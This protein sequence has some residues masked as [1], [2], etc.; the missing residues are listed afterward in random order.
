MKKISEDRKIEFINL[1]NKGLNDKDIAEIMG[2]SDSSI[3]RWRHEMNLEA[4][5]YHKL[6]QNKGIELTDDNIQILCGTLLG[7]GSLQYYEKH[8]FKAPIFKCDHGPKQKEYA[9]QLVKDFSNLKPTLHKYERIDKRNNHLYITYCVKLPVNPC[10][11]Q[12]YNLLYINGKKTI[13]KE[14]LQYFT[15]KSLAYLYMDDGYADQK[16][17]YICTDNFNIDEQNIL[18]DYLL[19]KFN[20]HFSS[21]NHGKYRRLRLSQYDFD[22]FCSLIN[23]YIIPSLKYKLNSVT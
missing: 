3:F 17:A 23:P 14:F 7:D 6:A 8:R 18:I 21:V 9:E 16:T 11:F 10:L 1:Y 4:H 5:K 20:L 22:R 12:L 2:I 13:T 15:I 19:S